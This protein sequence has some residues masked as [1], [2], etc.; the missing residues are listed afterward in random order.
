MPDEIRQ[1]AFKRF[2]LSELQAGTRWDALTTNASTNY[3]IK[4]IEC[5]QNNNNDAVDATATIGLTSDFSA[6]P[7]KFVSLGQVGKK[8]R[9][10][11]SGSAIMG[12]SSTLSIRPTAKS[13]SF[14]D[15][16]IQRGSIENTTPRK[17]RIITNPSV[18]GVASTSDNSVVD[19]DKTSVTFSAQ[20]NSLYSPQAGNFVVYHTN[21]NGVPLR[22]LFARN[23]SSNGTNFQ[24]WNQDG[25]E[26]GFYY[27]AYDTPFWDGGRYIF[28]V[29]TSAYRVRWY[30]L[31]E[32]TT[33][34]LAANTTGG[35]SGS[36]FWHGQ[37][38]AFTDGP[39][40]NSRSTYD[41]NR[42][43][44]YHNR[45]TNGKRYYVGW[46]QGNQ[47]FWAVEFPDVLVN[48]S[49]STASAKWVYLS[50]GV[51]RTNGNSPFGG[52]NGGS[53]NFHGLT[54]QVGWQ[55]NQSD[56][57]LTYDTEKERYYIWVC[58][59]AG[60]WYCFTFTQA[61]FDARAQANVLSGSS[62]SSYGLILVASNEETDINIDGSYWSSRSNGGYLNTQ[63]VANAIASEAYGPVSNGG[64]WY[65]DGKYW[66]FKSQKSGAKEFH[67]YKLDMSDVSLANL[68][69]L[70]PNGG[71][72]PSKIGDFFVGFGTPSATQIGSRDYPTAPTITVR[73]S[74]ILSDQ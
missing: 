26:Y 17:A 32:S 71:T 14:V 36:N 9:V 7:S 31:D 37:T 11:L 40:F 20:T 43:A 44:F 27:D 29:D 50:D 49:T 12:A 24:V 56:M 54:Q 60:E 48:D 5:T 45:H 15:E 28:W 64:S 30:D 18:N 41:Q 35:G 16:I 47:R 38:P 8:D 2:S 68:T 21:A 42:N 72:A 70:D 39:S 13:I 57:R 4:S 61:E 10:G 52:N 55:S 3:V 34:L 51:A 73:I 59:G 53:W 1:L 69:A 58:P 66:Y 67:P 63:N 62:S 65:I 22:I 25:T 19:I 6:T 23:G 33:N 74:G 46:S